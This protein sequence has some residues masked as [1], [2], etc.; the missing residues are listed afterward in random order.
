MKAAL[1]L[2]NDLKIAEMKV[3]FELK[4]QEMAEERNHS[5]FIQNRTIASARQTALPRWTKCFVDVKLNFFASACN[6]W[7]SILFGTHCCKR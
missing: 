2:T 6:W 7:I 5:D 3:A 1:V 4:K